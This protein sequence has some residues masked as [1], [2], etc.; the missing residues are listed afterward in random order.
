[1]RATM[2]LMA[3]LMLFGCARRHEIGGE[4]SDPDSGVGGCF[5]SEASL[6]MGSGNGCWSA[7]VRGGDAVP[8]A[9]RLRGPYRGNPLRVDFAAATGE[10]ALWV[11]PTPVDGSDCT[12]AEA[13]RGEVY[14]SLSPGDDAISCQCGR[15]GSLLSGADMEA[16][17]QLLFFAGRSSVEYLY[18]TNRSLSWRVWACHADRPPS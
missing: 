1:M 11:L 7:E 3:L 8:C 17:Q 15:V 14:Q 16:P 10:V 5:P 12:T 6:T 13:C 9:S 4:P 2:T 18:L